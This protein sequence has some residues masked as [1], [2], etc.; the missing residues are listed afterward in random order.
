MIS[1]FVYDQEDLSGELTAM[2]DKDRETI[3]DPICAAVQGKRQIYGSGVE[4]M[5]NRIFALMVLDLYEQW[6]REVYERE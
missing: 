3:L 5:A 6:Q 1:E 2:P 4:V